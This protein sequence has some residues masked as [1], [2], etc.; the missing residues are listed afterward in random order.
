MRA[1]REYRS[2]AHRHRALQQP[3]VEAEPHDRSPEPTSVQA[4][5]LFLFRA[6]QIFPVEALLE[7]EPTGGVGS[8]L[9][10]SR[11]PAGAGPSGFGVGL[12]RG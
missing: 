8:P 1:K 9:P 4:L 6:V 7:L 10:R 12:R 2:R 5:H 3:S 11:D